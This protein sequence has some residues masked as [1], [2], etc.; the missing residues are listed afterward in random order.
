MYNFQKLITAAASEPLQV[1]EVKT[2]ARI[3][4]ANDDLYIKNLITLAREYCETICNRALLTSTWELYLRSFPP[5]DTIY[6]P[7][8]QLQAVNSLTYYDVSSNPATF[9]SALYDVDTV[10]EPGCLR[11]GYQRV[12]PILVLRPTNAVVLN[13]TAGWTSAAAVPM[14]IKQAML[15]LAAHWYENREAIIVGRTTTISSELKYTVDALLANW[16]LQEYQS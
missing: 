4:I 9:S 16:R 1:E 12:W 10:S 11:L 7:K 6:I 15:L 5:S 3:F 8:G 2:H 13:F 14:Q